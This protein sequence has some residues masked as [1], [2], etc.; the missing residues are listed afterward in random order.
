MIRKTF[1]ETD[2]KPVARVTFSLPN[3]IWAGTIHL[4]GDFNDWNRTSHPLHQDR[5]G[6][7]TITIDLELGHAYQFRYLRDGQDWMNDCKAD[8]YVY[9]LYGS[10]NFVVVTDPNF[11]PYSDTKSSS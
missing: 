11:V 4:V 6:T 8:A 5:D 9:N 3:C 10:H 1:T 7:W 2:G